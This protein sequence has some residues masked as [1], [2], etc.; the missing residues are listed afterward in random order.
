[1]NTLSIKEV[2]TLAS[3]TYKG[4][5]ISLGAGPAPKHLDSYWDEGYR[6]YYFLV[7]LEDRLVNPVHSNHPG[8]EA[9]QPRYM[10]ND[11]PLGWAMVC[12]HFMGTKQ[13]VS[14]YYGTGQDQYPVLR[15]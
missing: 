8:F 11:L 4:R 6:T 9:S 2:V 12:H 7:R 10:V 1:M 15:A 3:P 5:K 14:V 13:S